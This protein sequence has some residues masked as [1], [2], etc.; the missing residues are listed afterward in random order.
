MSPLDILTIVAA[1]GTAVG[2]IKWFLNSE[3]ADILFTTDIKSA[4]TK[5]DL[6]VFQRRVNKFCDWLGYA[7]VRVDQNAFDKHDVVVLMNRL[8][9]KM[10]EDERLMIDFL[11]QLTNKFKNEVL[12]GIHQYFQTITFKISYED[13]KVRAFSFDIHTLEQISL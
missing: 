13:H 5:R 9:H 8:Y 1:V 4:L 3:V 7:W 2:V 10:P 12:A 11:L 6:F